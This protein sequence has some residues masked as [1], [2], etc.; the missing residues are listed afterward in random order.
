MC[1]QIATQLQVF[2]MEA[3][4]KVGD[5]VPDIEEGLNAGAWTV[6]LALSGNFVGLT[7]GEFRTLSEDEVTG[8]RAAA[9][10]QLFQA[11]AHY[12]VDTI[13]E[14]PAALDQI[15]ARLRKGKRP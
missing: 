15:Q 14:L 10:M 13:A 12:V 5:T 4:V 9:M 7:L 11:G 2:P 8:K 6:G 3:V 1:Y